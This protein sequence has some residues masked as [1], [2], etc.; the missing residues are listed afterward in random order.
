MNRFKKTTA[1]WLV[2]SVVALQPV[3]AF[4]DGHQDRDRYEDR[5]ER[6][7]RDD[8]RDYRDD[9]Y[10]RD[11]RRDDRRWEDQR[12]D[13]SR[14]DDRNWDPAPFYRDDYR[15]H[16]ARRMGRYDRIYRG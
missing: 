7:H 14:W 2:A 8:R 10:R 15:R 11:D 1:A 5:W 12:W 4:A 16:P 13:D 3:A 6:E 9:R